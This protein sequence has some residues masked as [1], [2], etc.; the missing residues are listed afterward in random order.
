MLV[1]QI[2]FWV[3][4]FYVGFMDVKRK[5]LYICELIIGLPL[6]VIS[7]VFN[8]YIVIWDAFMGCVV[9]AFFLVL[10]II[11]K[12]QIGTA[13]GILLMETGIAF[14]L[15]GNIV[16]IGIALMLVLF[17]SAGLLLTG[18][19]HRKSTLPFVPFILGGVTVTT[20]LFWVK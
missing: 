10:S 4:L 2:L 11:T 16:V 15:S 8:P 12:G 6:A 1:S 17:V 5:S 18:K 9:G 3:Y 14:G 19:L 13:D 7:F 20:I